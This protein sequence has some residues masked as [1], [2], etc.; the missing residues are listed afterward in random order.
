MLQKCPIQ[1][2]WGML[3]FP[4]SPNFLS[5]FSD[6]FTLVIS[7]CWRISEEA[8]LGEISESPLPGYLH[9]KFT[10]NKKALSIAKVR[11]CWY[12]GNRYE[13]DW[14]PFPQATDRAMEKQTWPQT[15]EIAS[16]PEWW[17]AFGWLLRKQQVTTREDRVQEEAAV[18][19]TA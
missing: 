9:T 1:A 11:H 13:V 14:V 8:V 3:F 16:L 6:Y 2:R 17:V 7:S 12:W 18:L 15:S 10:L 19:T 4:V 5:D